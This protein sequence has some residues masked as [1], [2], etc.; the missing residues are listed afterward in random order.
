MAVDWRK[1]G[2]HV[3]IW[4]FGIGLGTILTIPVLALGGAVVRIPGVQP[5]LDQVLTADHDAPLMWGLL[6]SSWMLGIIVTYAVVALVL[7]PRDPGT[8]S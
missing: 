6:A 1:P 2:L 3:A 5:V 7:K 4:V 8:R